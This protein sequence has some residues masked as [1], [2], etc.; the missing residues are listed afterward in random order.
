MMRKREVHWQRTIL[1]APRRRK[2]YLSSTIIWLQLSHDSVGG[3]FTLAYMVGSYVRFQFGGNAELEPYCI[4]RPYF[5]TTLFQCWYIFSSFKVSELTIRAGL[6]NIGEAGQRVPIEAVFVH[7]RFSMPRADIALIKVKL[8]CVCSALE[9]KA[10]VAFPT[11]IANDWSSNLKPVKP[12]LC[13]ISLSS[14]GEE[15][16][17]SLPK[18]SCFF[19]RNSLQVG[20]ATQKAAYI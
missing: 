5:I 7:P 18:I 17:R 14:L 19:S 16:K 12:K 1:F 13:C 8:I 15:K 11:S 20:E 3:N 10:M 4:T 6:R 2:K 9:P